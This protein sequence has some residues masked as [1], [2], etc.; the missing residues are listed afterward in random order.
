MISLPGFRKTRAPNG[1]GQQTPDSRTPDSATKGTSRLDHDALQALVERAERAS[2]ALRS[3]ESTTDRGEEFAAMER[4][5]AELEGQLAAAEQASAELTAIR[6]RSGEQ[7]EAQERVAAEIAAAGAEG[8]RIASSIAELS[9]KID[10]VLQLR[11]QMDRVEELNA[12][13]TSMN[14]EAHA[15]RSQIR[16]LVEN[17]SRLRTVHDDVLRA[18]KH[19]TIRLDG[20]DQRHQTAT[21]RMDV[22]ERRAES[23]NEALEALLRLASGIPDVQHQLAVLKATA[24]QVFQKTAALETQRE[25]VER[26]LGQSSQVASLNAQ[27]ATAFR[28]Q[29]DQTR[30]LATLETRLADVQALHDTV[31]SRSAE[32]SAHQQ[33]LDEAERDATRELVSLRGE[34]RASTDRFELENR[35]LDAASERI[36]EL[37]GVVNDCEKR[38]A[39]LDTSVQAVRET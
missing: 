13:F 2:E 5:I 33:K 25:M 8:A 36:A 38:V 7:A 4:R 20:L 10:G 27:L 6:A 3:L 24:D 12:Q 26:A 35:S 14:G 11:H 37:R 1:T 16:D 19:A 34:I 22:L 15:A 29:E 30:T 18:H 28:G 21:N 23:S 39:A 9:G 31:Q 17:I 32:I